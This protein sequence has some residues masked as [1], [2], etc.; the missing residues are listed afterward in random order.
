MKKKL[1]RT[2][3]HRLSRRLKVIFAGVL[4]LSFLAAIAS[5]KVSSL[6]ASL[7]EGQAADF[8]IDP[9]W[10]DDVLRPTIPAGNFSVTDYGASTSLADNATAFQ[11]AIDAATA[12]GGGTVT[13]PAGAFSL[14]PIKMKDN[15]ELAFSEG[16]VI[17]MLSYASYPGAGTTAGVAAFI[18]LTGTTNTKISGPGVI[19]GHG[20]DWWTA[21]RADKIA[22]PAMIA[23]DRANKL[24]L[25]GFTIQNAPNGHISLH[26]DNNNVTVDGV[27]LNSPESSPNTDGID[28]WSGHVNILNCNISCGDD[29]IAMDDASRYVTI[30]NTT[31]G[32]GHGLSIGSY[33]NGIDHIYVKDCIFNGT[34]NG[35]HVKSARGR[36]GKVEYLFYED[37]TMNDVK[38]PINLC[39]YYPDNTIPKSADADV[40]QPIDDRTPDW[41]HIY[42]K[43]ITATGADNAGLVWA[44]PEIPMEDL[45]FDNVSVQAKSGMRMNYVKDA[46][47]I[48]GSEI[49]VA[50]GSAFT[51]TYESN[52][53]GI[54]LI[55]GL[56]AGTGEGDDQSATI[57]WSLAST[58][59]ALSSATDLEAADQVLG[60]LIDVPG[61]IAYHHGFNVGPDFQDVA[62]ASGHQ[63][64]PRYEDNSYVEYKVSVPVGKKFKLNNISFNALGGGTG[65]AVATVYYSLNG[66]LT[67]ESAG[68]ASYNGKTFD[69]TKQVPVQLLNTSTDASQAGMEVL[70]INTSIEVGQTQT[71]SIRVYCWAGSENKYFTSKNVQLKGTLEEDNSELPDRYTITTSLSDEAAGAVQQTPNDV[72]YAEGATVG[73]KAT[74]NFGYKFLK[75]VDAD[76]ND[77]ELSTEN[78]YVVTVAKSM[79]VKAVFEQLA[80]YTLTVQTE[81][82]QWGNIS[83]SPEPVEGKYEAGTEVTMT[84]VP[85]VFANFSYWEDQSTASQRTV[86]IDKD[87]TYT[88]T[89]D[90][91]PFIVGWD[92]HDQSVTRDRPGDF[93]SD[94]TSRGM[95][96]LYNADATGASWLASAQLYSPSYPG[97]RMW[98][99]VNEFNAGR[100]RYFQA[101]FSTVGFSNIQVKSL[102]G[103]SYQSYSVI[104]L[105]YSIDGVNY[106]DVG[107]VDISEAYN[108]RWSELNATLPAEA[109]GQAK[110]YLKWMGDPSSP[111]LDVSGNPQKDVEGTGIT[112][113]YVFGD[114]EVVEDHDAPTLVSVVPAEGSNTA[115]VNGSV[116]FT[117][118]ER[119]KAGVGDITLGDKV[120]TGNYGAKS[121]SFPYQRLDYNNT[122]TVNIPAGA[123]TDM[124][125]NPFAGTTL[126]FSTTT[127][128]EPTKKGFDAIVATDGSGD[129]LTLMEAIQAAPTGRTTPWLIFVKNG[130]YKGNHEIP[131]NKPFIY[132]IGQSRDGVVVSNDLDPN[133][134]GSWEHGAAMYIQGADCYMEN[135]TFMNEYGYK[136]KQ[137]PPAVAFYTKGDRFAMKNT[138][139]LSFQDSYFTGGTPDSRVYI[140]GSV[141]AGAVDY[142][143]GG[144]NVFFDRDT[145]MAERKGSVI[146]A[147]SHAPGTLWGYVFRDCVMNAN[148]NLPASETGDQAFGRPWQGSPQA[149][150]INTKALVDI[151]PAGWNDMGTLPII[152]ADYGTVDANGIPLDLSHRKSEYFRDG[153]S[154]GFAKNSLTDAEAATYTYENLILRE[155][156]TWDPRAMYEAPS[157]PQNLKV[158]NG[159]I[160]WDAVPYTRLY[161]VY[162][163][164]QV[165]GYSTEP[166]YTEKATATT[167]VRAMAAASTVD[168]YTV[169]A[170]S[171]FGAMSELS[172]PVEALPVTGLKLKA[173]KEDKT[174]VLDWTTVSEL[175]TDHFEIERS[176]DGQSFKAIGSL[177]AAGTSSSLHAYHFVDKAPADGQNIYRVKTVDQDGTLSFSAVVTVNFDANK[178]LG[179]YPNPASGYVILSGNEAADLVRVLDMSGRQVLLVQNVAAGKKIDVSSLAAGAY[180]VEVHVGDTK[181]AVRLIKK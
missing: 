154:L 32:K 3:A 10:G 36:S 38:T 103:A 172:E 57:I 177:T 158:E 53:T 96:S 174:V 175:R 60:S 130:N 92:F 7:K 75:W 22:R 127:R 116:V 19:D 69:N 33:T 128:N 72:D 114:H 122:Y 17:N 152:F 147:P 52:I 164:G 71:L 125:G 13:V 86:T 73:L 2:F 78:P 151:K 54:D 51:S 76:N 136:G 26:R 68:A 178:T 115:T 111:K 132:L 42:L 150:F 169:Q 165:L 80:T 59:S 173:K 131:A 144:G 95:F 148:P 11:A 6:Y 79:H 149:V 62:R 119:V 30:K 65:G 98:T 146:V 109:E 170:V 156:D 104:K 12:A 29:N 133:I 31:F 123:I 166:T 44:V 135:M 28:I 77:S 138:S 141:I 37:L 94:P 97:A 87:V 58:P 63:L 41:K 108:S 35:V 34:D 140:Q 107:N 179:L 139:V 24:E 176:Q 91:I 5:G 81:G 137:G 46:S 160:S 142:I 113:V 49:R 162:K 55:S 93:Y 16:T 20:E 83:L 180:V 39:E 161:V 153:N 118:N 47:F 40:V 134:D 129:Y 163:N 8:P 110:I 64:P 143:F 90:E 23:F 67:S 82:S 85:N 15:V 102:V 25:N 70:N 126:T 61:S 181:R 27:T 66:F 84:V 159:V 121:V 167:M 14:G 157:A 45:V 120:L 89:F 99:N 1:I 21:Y 124:A 18:D 4:A 74:T 171:E 101:E 106:T 117:F 145:L 112:N 56:P 168:A 105:Q 88:A 48:N 100:S 43:N 155:A 9:N 50:S